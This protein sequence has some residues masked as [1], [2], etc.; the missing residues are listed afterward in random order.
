VQTL[1]APRPPRRGRR[2]PREVEAGAPESVPVTRATVT[3]AG[4]L[5]LSD[6]SR[7]LDATAGDAKSRADEVRSATRLI[8][9]ALH[10]LRAGAA[11]PLVQDVA[12]TRALSIRIGYGSGEELAEGRWTEAKELPPPRRGR[13]DE[14]DPQTRVAAVLAGRDEVH[15]A[16][17][18]LLRARLDAEQG[19]EAEARYGLRAAAA[20]LEERPAPRDAEL[21]KQM[22]ALEER[23]GG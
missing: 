18:L 20:A 22:A 10:A 19:R 5:S 14:V 7:W 21:R 12:A 8:N 23:L 17:T 3:A 1:G 6:A 16:E 15:P 13:L 2:R 9:R 11:D 4:E